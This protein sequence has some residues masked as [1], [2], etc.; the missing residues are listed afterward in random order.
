MT[1]NSKHHIPFFKLWKNRTE[2]VDSSEKI[3][4]FIAAV[5]DHFIIKPG[6][7]AARFG[8]N[9]RCKTAFSMHSRVLLPSCVGSIE[10]GGVGKECLQ[11]GNSP[12]HRGWT[13]VR[14]MSISMHVTEIVINFWFFKP[15]N[16]RSSH[17]T[18]SRAYQSYANSR[19]SLSSTP[20]ALIFSHVYHRVDEV[21]TWHR[22]VSALQRKARFDQGILIFL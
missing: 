21:Q 6:F 13:L 14:V 19:I 22:D 20:L 5:M 3:L 11:L 10:R 1:K 7:Y 17:P 8:W 12:P 16:K 18:A 9:T 4:D 2:C 15:I